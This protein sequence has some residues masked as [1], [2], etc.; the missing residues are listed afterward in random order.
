MP[1]ILFTLTQAQVDEAVAAFNRY[2][3]RDNV[4]PQEIKRFIAQPANDIIKSYRKTVRDEI[5]P[6]DGTDVLA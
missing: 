1:E 5:H 2:W 3:G 6:I 4:T